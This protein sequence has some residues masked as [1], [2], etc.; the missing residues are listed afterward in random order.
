[1]RDTG[2]ASGS[3][4]ISVMAAIGG[5]NQCMEGLS[6]VSSSLF[7]V[8]PSYAAFQINKEILKKVNEYWGSMLHVYIYIDKG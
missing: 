1:M 3:W 5:V 4:L 2:R 7:N 8:L 6:S